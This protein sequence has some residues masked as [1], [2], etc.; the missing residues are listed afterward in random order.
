MTA[1]RKLFKL[2][3]NKKKFQIT[4]VE[5]RFLTFESF[6]S[7][8]FCNFFHLKLLLNQMVNQ[9]LNCVKIKKRYFHFNSKFLFIDCSKHSDCDGD[10]PFCYESKCDSCTECHYCNDG[11]D[12]TC[13]SCGE[14]YPT[15]ESGPCIPTENPG[16]EEN[17]FRVFYPQ[18]IF[19]II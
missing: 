12:G 2:E 11:V 19:T 1:V 17:N 10:T 5:V 18:Q 6:N 8:Q 7:S 9:E 16:I 4:R 14:G 3:L 13:G 15:L